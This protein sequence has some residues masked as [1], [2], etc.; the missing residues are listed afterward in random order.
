MSRRAW[1]Y[2]SVFSLLPCLAVAV[3]WALS[4]CSAISSAGGKVLLYG[5]EGSAGKT[6]AGLKMYDEHWSPAEV[7]DNLR[8]SASTSWRHLGFEFHRGEQV[9]DWTEHYAGRFH[10]WL[11]AIPFW[12]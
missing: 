8:G 2:G 7:W 4:Y 10:F 3:Y 5:V 12:A 11:V 6:Y 9:Y 1:I